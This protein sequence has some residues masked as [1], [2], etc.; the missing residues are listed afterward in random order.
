[1]SLK[2][3]HMFD[4]FWSFQMWWHPDTSEKTLSRE[5]AIGSL[6]G[7]N[8]F[9]TYV[10]EICWGWR[11]HNTTRTESALFSPHMFTKSVLRR[12]FTFF[13]T[14]VG[15]IWTYVGGKKYVFPKGPFALK[16]PFDNISVLFFSFL[17]C[18][19]L[20][21]EYTNPAHLNISFTFIS[22][23]PVALSH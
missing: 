1:M 23:R 6:P 11:Y 21:Y 20:E 18:V 9:A 14:Y 16:V 22:L 3:Q 4:F 5:T 7:V 17:S 12:F 10:H 19:L 2:S 13:A 15:K 8:L